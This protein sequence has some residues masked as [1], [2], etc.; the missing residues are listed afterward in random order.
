MQY[1]L[2]DLQDGVLIPFTEEEKSTNLFFTIITLSSIIADIIALYALLKQ[3]SIPLDSL[4]IVSLTV[5]DL[6]FGVLCG[7]F[8]FTNGESCSWHSF[9]QS[10]DYVTLYRFLWRLVDGTDRYCSFQILP[11]LILISNLSK[12]GCYWEV[13]LIIIFLGASILSVFAMTLHK[14]L[15]ILHRIQLTLPRVLVLIAAA[16]LLPVLMIILFECM[17]DLGN[18]SS[19]QSSGTWCFLAMNKTEPLNISATILVFLFIASTICMLVFGHLAI[20]LAYKRWSEK[21]IA[22]GQADADQMVKERRLISKSIAIS[23]LFSF[24]WSFFL[25]KMMYEL[26][27]HLLVPPAYENLVEFMGLFSPLLNLFILYRYDAKFRLNIRE[28]FYLDYYL[29]DWGRK[30]ISHGLKDDKKRGI[31]KNNVTTPV[32]HLNVF[33]DNSKDAATLPTPTRSILTTSPLERDTIDLKEVSP[34]SL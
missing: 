24:T 26:I 33:N 12:I 3:K 20:V 29:G 7:V 2:K 5:A 8:L 17:F 27:T 28:L 18:I 15:S 19:I 31:K 4:Y 25:S 6:A 16:W 13:I 32:G 30:G 9:S 23:A 21:K 22:E 10:S 14:Y 1:L 11:F 34:R